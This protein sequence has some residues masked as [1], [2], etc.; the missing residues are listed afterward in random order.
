[1]QTRSILISSVV[2]LLASCAQPQTNS[3]NAGAQTLN[4]VSQS[5]GGNS[6]TAA[7]PQT[8]VAASPTPAPA[9]QI[10]KDPKTLALAFYEFY[11]DGFPRIEDEGPAFAKFLTSRF[12]KEASKADDFDPFLDAQDLDETWKGNVSAA[13]ATIKGDKATVNVMLNGKT[14]KWTMQV[15]LVRQKDVWKIDAIRQKE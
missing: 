12:F 3:P 8:P 14:F 2:F 7:S 1:M 11:V 4:K 15:S 5:S 6:A 13:D 10:D 9:V